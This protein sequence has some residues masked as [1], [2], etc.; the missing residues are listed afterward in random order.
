MEH[1]ELAAQARLTHVI[2][3]TGLQ[4]GHLEKLVP[5]W[6][7]PW[8][9]RHAL[10]RGYLDAWL[11]DGVVGRFVRVFRSIDRLEARWADRVGGES[12]QVERRVTLE[13]T[14]EAR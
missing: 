8:L 9:Y 11:L 2:G 3:T 7:Q 10:E 14:K 12:E 4:R 5:A 1:A 13:A 6:L